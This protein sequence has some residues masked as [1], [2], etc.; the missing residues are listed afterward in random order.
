MTEPKIHT[1]NIH[2]AL[3]PALEEWLDSRG[4]YLSPPVKLSMLAGEDG[5]DPDEYPERFIW[6]KNPP[7]S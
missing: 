2:D 3:I 7:A 1:V 6:P 4:L 5:G